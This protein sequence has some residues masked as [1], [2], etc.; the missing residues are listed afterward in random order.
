MTAIKG[1]VLLPGCPGGLELMMIATPLFIDM[2]GNTPFL[3]THTYLESIFGFF[4][5][6]AF[7]LPGQLIAS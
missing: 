2:A 3:T 4:H 6:S 7:Q 1:F 5:C